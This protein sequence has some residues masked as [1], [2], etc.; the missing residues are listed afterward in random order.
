MGLSDYD[1]LADL[2]C[3][4]RHLQGWEDGRRALRDY[5]IDPDASICTYLGPGASYASC[6]FLLPDGRFVSLDI[7]R[8][9]NA[10][11]VFIPSDLV[12]EIPGDDPLEQLAHRI[13]TSGG[14]HE[15]DARVRERY[16]RE[17]AP[18]EPVIL[19]RER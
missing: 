8:E 18:R 3:W 14:K 1:C 15:F 9:P 11:R 17:Y 13:M 4:V 7:E 5:G 12:E 2:T 10:G 16:E 6:V 19:P